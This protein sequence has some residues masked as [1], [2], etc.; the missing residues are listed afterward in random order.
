MCVV[1]SDGEILRASGQRMEVADIVM[2]AT[3]SRHVCASMDKTIGVR[4]VY[5][6]LNNYPR[7]SAS[8][9]SEELTLAVT[10]DYNVF[11]AAWVEAV[12]SLESGF[13]RL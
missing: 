13:P 12:A 1:S 10:F 7:P 5:P 4:Y 11:K 6:E 8:T 3:G 2:F 9:C